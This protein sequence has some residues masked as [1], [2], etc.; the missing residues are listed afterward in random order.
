MTDFSGIATALK[1]HNRDVLIEIV[2]S[3]INLPSPVKV[4][5]YVQLQSIGDDKIG[6]LCDKAL[7]AIDYLQV[8]DYTGLE[9]YLTVE[10]IPQPLINLILSAIKTHENGH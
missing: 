9:N 6:L 5:A 7:A 1:T 8:G 2:S 10:K 3:G 4:M